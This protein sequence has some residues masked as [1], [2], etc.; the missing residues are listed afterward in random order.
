MKYFQDKIKLWAQVAFGVKVAHDIIMRNHRF[1]E[2]SAELVQS[3]GCTKEECI[4]IVEYVYSRP[5]GKPKQEVGG[6][7]VTLSALCSA[8]NFSLEVCA[9]TELS[10]I[11]DNIEKIRVKQNNKPIFSAITK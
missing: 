11:W 7:I 1:F 9:N 8:N 5:L 2:E 4:Q 6:V 3:L 10:R